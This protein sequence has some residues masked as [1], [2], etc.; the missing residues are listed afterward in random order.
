MGHDALYSDC[1]AI[2]CSIHTL[3][4]PDHEYLP[5]FHVTLVSS[6]ACLCKWLSAR[7]G[8][9]ILRV[10]LGNY[11]LPQCHIMETSSSE[12]QS[13]S[14]AAILGNLQYTIGIPQ[15]IVEK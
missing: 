6:T 13:G 8:I 11:V 10:A 3:Q 2:V 4:G 12:L 7:K 5:D 15:G 9:S 14:P 1:G